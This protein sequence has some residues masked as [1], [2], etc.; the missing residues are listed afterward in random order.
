[1]RYGDKLARRA[2]EV[3]R[4]V[5]GYMRWKY[6][7]PE[8]D[9]EDAG[10]NAIVK[11]LRYGRAERRVIENVDGFIFTTIEN[12]VLDGLRR[13]RASP[14]RPWSLQ[15]EVVSDPHATPETTLDWNQRARLVVRAA[16]HL[17]KQMR[18]VLWL[19]KRGGLKRRD[20]AER[21]GITEAEVKSRL[22]GAIYCMK[23]ELSRRL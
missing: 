15:A 12:Q 5:R 17:P 22:A 21:L 13:Q 20:I 23:K 19:S 16:A 9:L 18:V 1:M 4:V 10:Q 14:L 2:L 7:C 11:L 3:C 6:S 8:Q